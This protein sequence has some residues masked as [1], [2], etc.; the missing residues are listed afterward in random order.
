[1]RNISAEVVIDEPPSVSPWDLILKASFEAEQMDRAVHDPSLEE[2][3]FVEEHSYSAGTSS[4]SRKCG[5]KHFTWH[6]CLVK[7]LWHSDD[8]RCNINSLW[9]SDAIR[10]H[11][12]LLLSLGQ[13]WLRWWLAACRHLVIIRTNFIL[14]TNVGGEWLNITAFLVRRYISNNV[15]NSS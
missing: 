12:E 13:H 3:E 7:W 8:I 15:S 5:S 11:T 10:S 6:C 1:M 14:F 2:V 4:T 9:P